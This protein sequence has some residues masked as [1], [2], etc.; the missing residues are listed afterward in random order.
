MTSKDDGLTAKERYDASRKGRGVR[1]RWRKENAARLRDNLLRHRRRLEVMRDVGEALK[2]RF[3]Q[4]TRAEGPGVDPAGSPS[5]GGGPAAVCPTVPP[6]A[7]APRR[8]RTGGS[9]VA[10][11]RRRRSKKRR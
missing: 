1:A 8:T 5:G 7:P 6:A 11:R 3:P 2:T 10:H 4:F 9:H